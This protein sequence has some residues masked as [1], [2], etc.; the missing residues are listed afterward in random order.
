[1]LT[2]YMYSKSMYYDKISLKLYMKVGVF[3]QCVVFTQQ[4]IIAAKD[5]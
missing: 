2:F 3:L 1:M 5:L 4:S